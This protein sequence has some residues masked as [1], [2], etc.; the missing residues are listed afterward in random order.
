MIKKGIKLI[1]ALIFL[2]LIVVAVRSK[3]EVITK[4]NNRPIVSFYSQFKKDGKPVHVQKINAASLDTKIKTTISCTDNQKFYGFVSKNIFDRI[5]EES[6]VSF[7][8]DNFSITGSIKNLNHT[9]DRNTGLYRIEGEISGDYQVPQTSY[10]AEIITEQKEN[11]IT[12]PLEAVE[13]DENSSFVWVVKNGF[14]FKKQV[15][16][17]DQ[18]GDSFVIKEGLSDGEMVVVKGMKEL[19]EED[20]VLVINLGEKQ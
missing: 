2:G 16:V 1:A 10:I 14:C 15:I 17:Q 9:L 4:K 8:S 5:K 18:K 11:V 20:K 12:L 3:Q 13:I 19:K 6:L 7:N